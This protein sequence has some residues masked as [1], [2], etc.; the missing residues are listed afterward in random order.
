MIEKLHDLQ[1]H[2]RRCVTKSKTTHLFFFLDE[3]GMVGQGKPEE[4]GLRKQSTRMMYSHVCTHS[5]LLSS[6]AEWGKCKSREG[7]E[8]LAQ[9]SSW[10][11]GR[12]KLTAVLCHPGE[13]PHHLAVQKVGGRLWFP[14]AALVPMGCI[15]WILQSL[16]LQWRASLWGL[17]WQG[18]ALSREGYRA[19]WAR[20]SKVSVAPEESEWDWVSQKETRRQWVQVPQW[21]LI[22]WRPKD[23]AN[24][25]QAST[26]NKR[27]G[28]IWRRWNMWRME[29][30][31]QAMPN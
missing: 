25:A 3:W 28:R 19:S 26:L 20:D 21:A 12:N 7:T 30:S 27:S 1:P 5:T 15:Y 9:Y 18:A 16:S 4:G 11:G 31:L 10:D 17:L 22:T 14:Q 23:S 6:L 8:V 29:G 2:G 13:N 24:G